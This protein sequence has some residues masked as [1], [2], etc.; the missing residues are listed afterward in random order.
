MKLMDVLLEIAVELSSLSPFEFDQDGN[1]ERIGR[2]IDNDR[3]WRRLSTNKEQSD[4]IKDYLDKHTTNYKWKGT[5]P[6]SSQWSKENNIMY[7]NPYLLY[8]HLLQTSDGINN[9]VEAL[10]G[11]MDNEPIESNL[12]QEEA[13][14]MIY[15]NREQEFNQMY[16][17]YKDIIKKNSTPDD[18]SNVFAAITYAKGNFSNKKGIFNKFFRNGWGGV[19]FNLK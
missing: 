5:I 1:A 2:D 6:T 9:V 16:E 7:K 10:K 11:M 13:L 3:G 12:P 19:K 18:G 17:Q 4:S 14:L 8:V 15:E